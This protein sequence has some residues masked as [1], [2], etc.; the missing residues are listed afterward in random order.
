MLDLLQIA[1]VRAG[2]KCREAAARA[3]LEEIQRDAPRLVARY[4]LE[5]LSHEELAVIRSEADDLNA[6][7]EDCSV[8]YH[9]LDV[10]AAEA[11]QA[12]AT[13]S[14]ADFERYERLRDEIFKTGN[15]VHDK[16]LLSAFR[17]AADVLGKRAEANRLLRELAAQKK[18][19]N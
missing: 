16:G 1:K 5:D 14:V 18:T 8:V 12:A 2:L 9:G 3:R 15:A 19:T 10:L 13:S 6:F 11:H 7:L 17:L 4:Y